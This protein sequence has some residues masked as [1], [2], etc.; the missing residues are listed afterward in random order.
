MAETYLF[1]GVDIQSIDGV[2]IGDW[3][4][5]FG[6]PDLRGD[7]LVIP[8]SD[9]ADPVARPFGTGV[10]SIPLE[11]VTDS[12]AERND[13][14][15]E[16]LALI[17][18]GQVTTCTRRRTYSS[19]DRDTTASVRYLSGFESAGLET[20]AARVMLSF[21]NLDGVW[22]G[23]VVAWNVTGVGPTSLDFLGS[24]P[25]RR[26]L[27]EF[28]GAGT[29]T[30]HTTGTTVTVTAAATIDVQAHT[31]SG[32]LTDVVAAGDPLLAWFVLAPGTNSLGWSGSGSV[33]IT[34]T[35]AYP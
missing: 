24:L 27:I 22:S 23:T 6:V 16:I 4:G 1:D 19:G 28:P 13:A 25:T 35:P 30:N 21:T 18:P 5:Q 9:G 7:D 15:D 17:R 8:G 10:L 32:T 34:A 14:L 20:T 12:L 33:N 31:S 3:T 2:Y 11:V 26:M 29:L